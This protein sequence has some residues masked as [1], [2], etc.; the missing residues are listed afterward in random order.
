M[1]SRHRSLRSQI[2]VL[3]FNITLCL[4]REAIMLVSS[5]PP[6]FN[7]CNHG[8]HYVILFCLWN[9][10]EVTLLH[11]IAYCWIYWKRVKIH[12]TVLWTWRK[13]ILASSFGEKNVCLWQ[14]SQLES[15]ALP[16]Y[17]PTSVNT[18]PVD[19]VKTSTISIMLTHRLT[20]IF[21]WLPLN[22]KLFRYQFDDV[23]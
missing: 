23:L 6:L 7:L 14:L 8:V 1:S 21:N 3:K 12:K 20:Y 15:E 11:Q 19:Q 22:L 9:L 4:I 16:C 17:N 2:C 18:I 13:N 10:C 5:M